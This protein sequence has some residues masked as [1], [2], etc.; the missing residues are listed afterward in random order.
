MCPTGRPSDEA[1]EIDLTPLQDH[2]GEGAAQAVHL[3]AA[4]IFI[5][6][7]GVISFYF[8]TREGKAPQ[9]GKRSPKFWR[10][11]HWACS[12]VIAVAVLWMIVTALVKEPRTRLL[13]GETT[14]VWAFGVSWFWKGFELDALRRTHGP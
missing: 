1:N 3:S 6:S 11:F 8:G 13:I 12:G 9:R 4:G 2:I 10:N 5:V 7:L 14:A